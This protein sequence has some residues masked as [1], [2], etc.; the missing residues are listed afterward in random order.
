[1]KSLLIPVLLLSL[2][3]GFFF[4]KSDPRWATLGKS[5]ALARSTEYK[6]DV[7]PEDL[8]NGGYAIE[9]IEGVRVS[10]SN[11]L[12]FEKYELAIKTVAKILLG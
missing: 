5:I 8:K 10:I 4:F 2:T 6:W 9:P 11:Y 1:R 7:K 3:A 12:R